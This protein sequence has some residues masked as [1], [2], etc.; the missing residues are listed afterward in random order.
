MKKRYKIIL[1]VIG[2]IIILGSFACMI[3]YNRAKNDKKPIF[4]KKRY[5]YEI[6]N[7]Q[8]A[9]QE[10][11]EPEEGTAAVY[12]GLGYKIAVCSFCEKPV[13]LMLLGK[14]NYPYEQLRCTENNRTKVNYDFVD[15][16]IETIYTSIIIPGNE[17]LDENAYEEEIKQFNKI[18]GCNGEIK[19]NRNSNHYVSYEINKACKISDMQKEDV[20]LVYDK[21]ILNLNKKDLIKKY[22]KENVA[23]DIIH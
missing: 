5:G 7:V 20:N 4:S 10:S 18:K 6:F 8:I 1:I 16:K 13:Y 9:G 19:K 17:I 2:T 11:E 22:K 21:D 3:D 14:D 12:I 23:C 15:G